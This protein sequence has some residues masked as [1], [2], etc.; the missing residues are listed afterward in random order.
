R[1]FRPDSASSKATVVSV[2]AK[3]G[4]DATAIARKVAAY[5]DVGGNPATCQ[6]RCTDSSC[7]VVQL[8]D[9]VGGASREVVTPRRRRAD[10]FREM[11]SEVSSIRPRTAHIG[12]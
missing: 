8:A 4:L 5:P 2:V 1:A 10:V 7:D 6:T 11:C 12:R 9:R 3:A